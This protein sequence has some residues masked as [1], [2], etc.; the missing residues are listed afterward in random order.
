[1]SFVICMR[2]RRKFIAEIAAIGALTATGLGPARPS[3][4]ISATLRS[5]AISKRN[6]LS[7]ATPET[8]ILSRT[9]LR[10]GAGQW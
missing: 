10:T 5:G 7:R 2:S 9:S 6:T 3:V 8:S 1:M 4:L